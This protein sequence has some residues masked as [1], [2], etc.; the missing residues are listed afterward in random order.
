MNIH[1]RVETKYI[2]AYATTMFHTG[3]RRL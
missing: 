3:W 2:V 1:E